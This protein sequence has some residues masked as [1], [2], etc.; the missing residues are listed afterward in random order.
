MRCLHLL[1]LYLLDRVADGCC[2][3]QQGGIGGAARA[4]GA[5]QAQITPDMFLGGC[6]LRQRAGPSSRGAASRNEYGHGGGEARH[7]NDDQRSL[8]PA[9]T[10]TGQLIRPRSTTASPTTS[11]PL[12]QTAARRAI[13]SGVRA[14]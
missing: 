11:P 4:L 12:P 9:S 3:C 5:T 7:K 6:K 14:S 8:V 13:S 10:N 1:G 2:R